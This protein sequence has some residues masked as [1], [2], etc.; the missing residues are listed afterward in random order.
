[1]GCSGERVKDPGLLAALGDTDP[2][3]CDKPETL[4]ADCHKWTDRLGTTE[5]PTFEADGV[6]AIP[7]PAAVTTSSTR[8]AATNRPAPEPAEEPKGAVTFTFACR[9]PF[10]LGLV[11]G[12]VLT[13]AQQGVRFADPNDI[14][15]FGDVPYVRIR[16]CNVDTEGF[17]IY[18]SELD[19]ALGKLYRRD[20]AGEPLGP[21]WGHGLGTYEQWVSLET[22]GGRTEDDTPGDLAYAF[23]RCLRTLD[24][25]LRAHQ[26]AFKDVRVHP[27]TT[28]ELGPIVWRGA[29]GADGV[30][31][32]LGPILMHPEALPYSPAPVVS[33]ENNQ[34]LTQAMRALDSRYPFVMTLLWH[35]QALRQRRDLG[36]RALS[37]VSLQTAVETM[38]Y[39]LWRMLLIDKG[40]A[41]AQITKVVDADAPFASIIRTRMP[42][43]LGGPWDTSQP[44]TPVGAYWNSVHDIRNRIVHSGYIPGTREADAAFAAYKGFEEFI[45]ERLWQRHLQYPRTVLAK[46]GVEGMRRR[47]WHSAPLQLLIQQFFAESL[48]WFWPSDLAGR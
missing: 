46:V 41:A 32:D 44:T 39:D 8:D 31:I 10:Q 17:D 21:K 29:Y 43:L 2:C 48:P 42:G 15:H 19:D 18:P 23:H 34:K 25:F 12:G 24:H 38:I 6:S 26:V 13:S 35:Q 7:K 37:I 3:P 28:Q 33:E 47:S 27:V 14:A 16:I 1:M 30:W 36:D 9:L 4:W 20:P 45:N 40:R 22:P 11:D 5:H